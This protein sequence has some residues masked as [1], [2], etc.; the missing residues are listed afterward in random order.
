ML[1]NG[2]GDVLDGDLVGLTNTEDD[3]VDL[4]VA[5]EHPNKELGQISG[6]NELAQRLA[7]AAHGEGS[8]VLFATSVSDQLESLA[9]YMEHN[10]VCILFASKH[11]C[12]KPGMTWEFSRS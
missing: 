2:V 11:L 9:F 12:T 4:L 10:E 3:G 5:P 7:G 6:V 1:D 8:A